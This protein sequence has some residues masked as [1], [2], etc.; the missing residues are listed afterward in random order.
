MNPAQWTA[1]PLKISHSE[2]AAAVRLAAY[3]KACM[4]PLA[5]GRSIV[6]VCLGT[7]RSTGDSLGPFTGTALA[8]RRTADFDLYGT[9][10]D[11]VHA[12][13]L[14]DTLSAIRKRH[15]R[16][17]VIGIDACLGKP[18]SVGYLYAG[19]GPIRPGAGVNKELPPVGDLH[20]SGVVNIGG[21]MEYFVLQNTR[22]HLVV[23]MAETIA[24]G[25]SEAIRQTMEETDYSPRSLFR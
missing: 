13:N 25:V 9:L 7:D 8:N 18:A 2:P 14:E 20:V 19:T 24:M 12:M 1:P 6:V 21:F 5:Q 10:E 17:L 22:L 3:L 23:T 4:R 16:P 11:P 15:S